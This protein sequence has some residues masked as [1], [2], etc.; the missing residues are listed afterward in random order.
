[1]SRRVQNGASQEGSPTI[2]DVAYLAKVSTATVSRAI[3]GSPGVTKRTREAV[4]RAASAIG[5]KP[6][7]FAVQLGKS[8]SGRSRNKHRRKTALRHKINE[9][10]FRVQATT[11]AQS[12]FVRRQTIDGNILIVEFDL[13]E[14]RR[15]MA[16]AKGR[17][18]FDL[19]SE[20]AGG[21]LM[22]G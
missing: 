12:A 17:L 5:Y 20:I 6:N 16:V 19:Q 14:M 8:N 1:M 13:N 9:G 10:R 21:Y 22:R 3:N 18:L 15:Q 2:A 11:F 4:D 7:P